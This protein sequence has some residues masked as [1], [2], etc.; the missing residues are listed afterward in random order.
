MLR[1]KFI[2]R[3]ED[4]ITANSSRSDADDYELLGAN[5]EHV[6]ETQTSTHDL[7]SLSVM[8]QC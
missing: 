3:R 8:P 1:E 2:A 7:G 5:Q 6:P 4:I